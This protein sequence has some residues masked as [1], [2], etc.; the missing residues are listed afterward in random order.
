MGL[1]VPVKGRIRVLEPDPSGHSSRCVTFNLAVSRWGQN[2]NGDDHLVHWEGS[3]LMWCAC[4][5][6]LL[7]AAGDEEIKRRRHIRK[8]GAS[9]EKHAKRGSGLGLATN[10]IQRSY[11]YYSLVVSLTQY[12]N[13][14]IANHTVYF[15]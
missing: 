8:R 13:I 4:C 3:I 5:W 10:D 11:E 14:W 7:I 2:D 15:H 9:G 1:R 12:V 6:L